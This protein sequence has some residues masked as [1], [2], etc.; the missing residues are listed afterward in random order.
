MAFLV[1]ML[2]IPACKKSERAKPAGPHV[3]PFK[4]LAATPA[5]L[6]APGDKPAFPQ[7][8]PVIVIW[9]GSGGDTPS[10]ELSL[11]IWKSG[12]VRY[13]CG[14][15]GM[16]PPE[17]VAAIAD[18]FAQAGWKPTAAEAPRSD[19]QPACTTTS[20][21]LV[22]DGLVERRDSGC[23]RVRADI[24]DAV[25]FVLAALGPQPC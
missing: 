4:V 11:R 16:L 24:Q 3:S 10:T 6:D 19:P 7:E 1:A 2:A 5:V 17:H 15:G 9:R 13:T 20:V 23:D 22:R 8:P 18:G 14:R 12:R 21:Q 25:E